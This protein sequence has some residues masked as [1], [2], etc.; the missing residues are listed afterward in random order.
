MSF[1]R[2]NLGM[3]L[4]GL[5]IGAGLGLFILLGLGA[6]GVWQ[7]EQ[8]SSGGGAPNP[9]GPAVHQP[10]PDFALQT[11]DARTVDVTSL[12]GN[13][14]LI[15]FWAT[16]CGPCRLEMPVFQQYH[17]RY[18]DRLKILAVN[19]DETPEEVRAFVDELGFTF[20][21][22]LDPGQQVGDLYRVRVFPT[23]FLVDEE[24]TVRV[25]HLGIMDE[26]QLTNYLEDLGVVE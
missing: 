2:R 9:A 12:R 24:G 13:V 22:L 26:S 10:A 7:A 6:G 25:Q 15:N 11:L 16:W 19:A 1:T 20:D 4:A 23:T 14:V 8:T 21:V 18:G 5:L 17:E 3:L